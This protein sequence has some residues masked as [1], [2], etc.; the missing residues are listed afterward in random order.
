MEF[1]LIFSRVAVESIFFFFTTEVIHTSCLREGT[2]KALFRLI[3]RIP[4]CSDHSTVLS[5][6]ILNAVSKRVEG[7]PA[8]RG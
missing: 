6:R 7:G 2:M 5:T 3:M 8:G 4:R 1:G